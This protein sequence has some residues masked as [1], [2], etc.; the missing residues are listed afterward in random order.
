MEVK[1]KVVITD[2]AVFDYEDIVGWQ[3]PRADIKQ[4]CE[5]YIDNS[6]ARGRLLWEYYFRCKYLDE[7]TGQMV[8][9]FFYKG[10]RLW[11][12]QLWNCVGCCLAEDWNEELEESGQIRYWLKTVLDPAPAEDW[13]WNLRLWQNEQ[14]KQII[15]EYGDEDMGKVKELLTNYAL[16]KARIAVLNNPEVEILK[17]DMDFLDLCIQQ[18]EDEAREII[19]S[20]Y[21]KKETVRKIGARLGYG[22]TTI[23][24]KRDRAIKILDILFAER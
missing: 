5:F 19:L 17:K 10:E 11:N 1:N 9:L 14:R 2:E 20:V 21:I 6:Q 15:D 3:M 8:M 24:E 13:V 22:K 18:L 4:E 16:N 23:A 12:T 7:A